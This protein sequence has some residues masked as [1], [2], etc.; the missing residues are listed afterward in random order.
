MPDTFDTRSSELVELVDLMPTFAELAEISLP[1]SIGDKLNP[2][3]G[4]S[5]VSSLSGVNVKDAA[6]S[7]YPRK[8]K[9]MDQ[10]WKSNGIGH[11]ESETFLFMGYSVR[12]DE[13]R[14]TEWYPWNQ[15]KLVARFDEPVYA[16]ELYDWRGVESE[17]MDYD[18][19]EN[20]NVAERE[21]NE[22]IVDQL[23]E[24]LLKKFD[25]SS[26]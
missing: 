23:H 9:D 4:K 3:E 25:T 14:Y 20:L 2:P 22:D 16:R 24:L 11:D 21:E 18:F 8:P 7:Q 5:I 19:V 1:S 10:P 13:W 15:D 6:F 12:V 26:S 17:F